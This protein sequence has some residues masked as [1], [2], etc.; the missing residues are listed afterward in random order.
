[1]LLRII[2]GKIFWEGRDVTK[3]GEESL[4]FGNG[5]RKDISS[6]LS[7]KIK[8]ILKITISGH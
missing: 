7:G 2:E 1:M 6:I 4:N 8:Q 3:K 5:F